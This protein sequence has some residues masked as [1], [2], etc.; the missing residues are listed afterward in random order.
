MS[1]KKIGLVVVS[2]FV[3]TAAA[4]AELIVYDHF[5]GTAVDMGLW[6][7][8]KGGNATAAQASSVV[9]LTSPTGS[10]SMSLYSKTAVADDYGTYEFKIGSTFA[11]NRN[12]FGFNN[13]NA[14]VIYVQKFGAADLSYKL[15]VTKS[16]VGTSEVALNASPQAGEIWTIDWS[17]AGVSVYV[18]GIL[19]GSVA[20]SPDPSVQALKYRLLNGWGTGASMGIDY[21]GVRT[22]DVPEPGT[23]P[24]SAP[25]CSACCA[26][27]GGS[28]SKRDLL[29]P[30]RTRRYHVCVSLCSSW[31]LPLFVPLR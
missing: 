26:T 3:L 2:F 19:K 9:T 17:A 6:S 27:H 29:V 21:V 1:L 11:G 5:D 16:G 20:V 23:L 14:N 28:G 30:R 15:S 22:A 18:D 7:L 8:E 24:C 12:Y 25:L 31:I 10:D 4:Q 13:S